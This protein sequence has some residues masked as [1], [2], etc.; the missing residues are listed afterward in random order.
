M[1]V[2]ISLHPCLYFL[3][4]L[5]L[6][7]LVEGGKSVIL[8]FVMA[9]NVECLYISSCLLRDFAHF[10]CIYKD[11]VHVYTHIYYMC[12]NICICTVL[13]FLLL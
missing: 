13:G 5:Q 8:I 6:F 10:L 4:L 11:P 2:L 7:W 3:F 9:N 12:I 1:K